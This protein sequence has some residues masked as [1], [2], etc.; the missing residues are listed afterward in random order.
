MRETSRQARARGLKVSLVPTMGFMH[1]GHLSLIRQAK[2]VSDVVVTSIFVNP[3]QFGPAEDF[4]KYPRDLTRDVDLCIGA[5]VDYLFTPEVPDMYGGGPRFFVDVGDLGERLEGS[6]RPGHFRG[7]AT[8]V[9]KLFQI[10]QPA[11]AAFGQKDA[12]QAVVIRRMAEELMLDVEVLVLPTVREEDG[13]A[14]SSRN[15]R[16]SPEDRKAAAAL[17]RALEAARRSLEEG[18]S[19]PEQVVTAAREEIEAEERLELDYVELVDPYDLMPLTELGPPALLVLAVRAG[20]IRL[21][22]NEMLNGDGA[23][24]GLPP[25]RQG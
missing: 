9:L 8:V 1:E 14:M 15:T 23:I 20:E 25:V 3:T 16:L 13:M 11:L 19:T 4:D 7:V 10:V 5:G 17:P 18:A 2:E 24:L 21:L 12:Q 22:D 6:S